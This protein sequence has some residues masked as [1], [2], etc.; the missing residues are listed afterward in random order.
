MSDQ[1]PVPP[2]PPASPPPSG[3]RVFGIIL[4]LIGIAMTVISGLCTTA[5]MVGDMTGSSGGGGDINLS[6]IEF[7]IGGPFILIGAL[8][9]WG[10]ARLKRPRPSPPPDPK[11]FGDPPSPPAAR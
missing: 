5:F 6:G 3:R 9:W 11:V 2:P 8:M 10:G 1:A 4:M 7:I